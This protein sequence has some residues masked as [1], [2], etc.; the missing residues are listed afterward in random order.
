[1]KCLSRGV[2]LLVGLP[3]ALLFL[4]SSYFLKICKELLFFTK[5]CFNSPAVSSSLFD[6]GR[7][8]HTMVTSMGQK[9][10]EGSF[11]LGTIS[12]LGS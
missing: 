3:A 9:G 11:G 8:M 5:N 7:T 10:E 2:F 6:N 12:G 1:M 4:L